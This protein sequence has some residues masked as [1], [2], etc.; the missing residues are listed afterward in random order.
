MLITGALLLEATL[1]LPFTDTSS[2]LESAI[3]L[4]CVKGGARVGDAVL[5]LD[6]VLIGG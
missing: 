1:T 2:Y 3:V 6:A 5:L 4:G